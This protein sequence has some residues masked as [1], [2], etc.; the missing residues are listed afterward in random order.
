LGH[1]G[2][3]LALLC[4]FRGLGHLDIPQNPEK[5]RRFDAFLSTMQLLNFPFWSSRLIGGFVAEMLGDAA[6][7]S[8]GSSVH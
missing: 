5:A 6:T 7:Q 8:D 2:E 4:D 1:A 3:S